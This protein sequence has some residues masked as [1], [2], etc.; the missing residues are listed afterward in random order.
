MTKTAIGILEKNPKGYILMVE[1]GRIDQAHHKNYARA[2]LTET[3]EFDEAI[4]TALSMT[5]SEETLIIVTADHSHAMTLNG[6]P[7]RNNDILG[8]KTSLTE[9][10]SEVW[11]IHVDDDIDIEIE[12]ANFL[13]PA[14]KKWDLHKKM[15]KLSIKNY[16][17][18]DKIFLI[19]TI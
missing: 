5:N 4:E 12:I 16:F 7:A 3:V 18:N 17:C 13:V 9:Q 1:G 11:K 14:R 6:Y 15:H 8:K 10:E 2:A 19:L